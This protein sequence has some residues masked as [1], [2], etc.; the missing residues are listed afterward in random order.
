MFVPEVN[1]ENTETYL[2]LYKNAKVRLYS[3]VR[4]YG[5]SL[6]L[7]CFDG[8]CVYTHRPQKYNYAEHRFTVLGFKCKIVEQEPNESFEQ[9][10][11]RS[12]AMLE[13]FIRETVK[14]VLDCAGVI[15]GEFV[16]TVLIAEEE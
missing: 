5:V 16:S 7:Q 10:K 9:H 1:V 13:G 2:E 11:R 14:R 15:E 8:T 6:K 3:I 4:G 12:N